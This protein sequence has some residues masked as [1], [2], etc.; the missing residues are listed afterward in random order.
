[1]PLQAAAIITRRS[2]PRRTL[3]LKGVALTIDVSNRLTDTVRKRLRR[4]AP[5]ASG[6]EGPLHLVQNPPAI[7]LVPRD[8]NAALAPYRPRDEPIPSSLPASADDAESIA[9]LRE[10]VES[11]YW[12]HTIELPGGIT[13]SGQFDHRSLIPHYG[14]PADLSGKRALDIASFDGFWA[15]E[16]ERRGAQVTSVDIARISDYDFPWAARRLMEHEDVDKPHRPGFEVAKQLLGSRVERI[17]SNVY[18]LN[19]QEH[20]TFD[21]VHVADLLL[22]LESPTRALRAIRSVTGSAALIV[23]AYYP[24]LDDGSGRQILEYRG[25]W[26][27]VVWWLPSLSALAQMV[28]DAGFRSVRLHTAYRLDSTW[29][30]HGLHRAALIAEV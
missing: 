20:G 3:R 24:E 7:N 18:D 15:F 1:V 23:D 11:R 27:M 2:M 28:A 9:K 12:Y 8:P 13:T 14:L 16:M 29:G 4:R 22:H 25:G 10:F 17:I 5:E 30:D 21:F 19:P 26:D 6:T